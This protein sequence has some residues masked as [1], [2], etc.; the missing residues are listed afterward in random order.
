MNQPDGYRFISWDHAVCQ[1]RGKVGGH[2]V[3]RARGKGENTYKLDKRE[4]KAFGRGQV[5]DDIASLL[6]LSDVNFQRQH[7]SPYW[8][9]QSAGEVAKELNS[10]VNLD[11]IDRSHAYLA[12]ELRKVR[13]IKEVVEGRLEEAK[14]KAESLQWT[15][16]ADTELREIEQLQDSMSADVQECSVLRGLLENV[17]SLTQRLQDAV[18]R[19]T[20]RLA[21]TQAVRELCGERERVEGLR[22]MLERMS[23]LEKSKWSRKQSV[24]ILKGEIKDKVG[25]LCPVCKGPLRL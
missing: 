22:G 8:F 16:Q 14:A 7:D 25:G 24:E 15:E 1:V 4:Y 9:M 12:S 21:L 11:Q 20:D 18:Q 19:Q 23:T 3:T 13:S 6:N 17:S 10:I 5:P 2:K